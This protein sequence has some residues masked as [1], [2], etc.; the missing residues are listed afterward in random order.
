MADLTSNV[1][2]ILE[3]GNGLSMTRLHVVHMA[4]TIELSAACSAMV[5]RLASSTF[6][7]CPSP[8]DCGILPRT[9]LARM[10]TDQVLEAE[11]AGLM[12]LQ[13]VH[14]EEIVKQPL[15]LGGVYVSKCGCGVGLDVRAGMEA[16]E[17]EHVLLLVV[18]RGVGQLDRCGD[19]A[20]AD[21]QFG[22]PP[23]L[24]AEAVRQ[25]GQCPGASRPGPGSDDPDGEREVTAQVHDLGDQLGGLLAEAI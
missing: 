20:L 10:S 16:E 19:A 1:Q 9:G 15:G 4:E 23:L 25:I 8:T 2:R 18:E 24:V 22:E 13:Q 14:I 21:L 12:L 17:A 7:Q 11:A 5:S 6:S 3:A